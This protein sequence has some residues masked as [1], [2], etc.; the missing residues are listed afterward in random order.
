MNMTACFV[1]PARTGSQ[2]PG[3]VRT[4]GRTTLTSSAPSPRSPPWRGRQLELRHRGVSPNH[5]WFK[6]RT[7]AVNL[8]NLLGHG[9][10]RRDGTWTLA[11]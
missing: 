1:P 3:C 7:A 11:T 8:R 6:R 2:A 10:I 5:A 4:T 9:L